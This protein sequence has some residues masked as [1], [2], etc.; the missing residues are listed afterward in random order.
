MIDQGGRRSRDTRKNADALNEISS[1]DLI[2]H[3][4][5]PWLSCV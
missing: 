1:L 4:C 5:S 3:A 2:I